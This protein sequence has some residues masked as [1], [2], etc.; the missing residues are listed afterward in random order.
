MR[1]EVRRKDGRFAVTL[2]G[3]ALDVDFRPEGAHFAHALI[4]AESHDVGFEK[5]E[6]GYAVVFRDTTVEVQLADASHG[7]AGVVKKTVHGPAKV[8]A[9]MPGKVLRVLVA[10]NQE[11]TAGQG[12]LVM[13]AMKM[14]NELR[15]PRAGVVREIK[16]AEGQA[17]ET[18]AL[19]VIVE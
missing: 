7:D 11:V 2:D 12:L 3:Q 18:G 8:K 15:S 10:A 4:G 6:G 16:A 19:L 14:E 1:V 17:V 5:R 9:P 13:E